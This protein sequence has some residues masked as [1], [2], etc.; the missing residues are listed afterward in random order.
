MVE[1]LLCKQHVAGSNPTTSTSR[2]QASQFWSSRRS[3]ESGAFAFSKGRLCVRVGRAARASSRR[4]ATAGVQ[5]D[6]RAAE[7]G[8]LTLKPA[9]AGAAGFSRPVVSAAP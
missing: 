4:A 1:W 6:V 2:S 7:T 9:K 8:P 5:G 3:F